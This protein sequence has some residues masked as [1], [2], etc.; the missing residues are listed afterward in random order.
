MNLSENAQDEID[1]LRAE[2]ERH[3]ELYY[4]RAEPEISDIDFDQLLERLK[5]IET[6]HP[7]LITPDSPT[8]RVGGKADSLRPFTHTVPLMSL[9]NSYDLNE[10]KAFTERCEKLAEGRTL[11]YVAELKIDGLSVSL[12]YDNGILMTGATRG[13]GQTG[14][15]VTQNVKTI[16]TIPLRLRKDAPER[17]EVRG[18]VFLSRSQFARINSELEMQGEKTF[19]N[20]RNCASGTLRMLDS[21]VVASRRLDMFPYDAYTGNQKMFATHWENFEWCERNGFN[22]NPNRRLCRDFEELAAFVA[23]IEAKRDSFDYEIDGVVV[24]VNSTA[25]QDEFGTT[26]KAPRWAIAYKYPARQATTRLLGIVIQVG[27]TGALT[28]VAHLE[29]TLLAGTTVSRASLHNEDE[30]K[31]LDL[32]IGDYVT[33]EKSGEIIPQVLS[34]VVSKRN[35]TETEFEFPRECP[36]CGFEAVRPEGEA[37][38]RCSNSDC[39]AKIKARILY[40]AARKAMDIEGLGEVLVE[41]LVDNGMIRDVAGLYSL[42]LDQVIGLERMAEKSGSNLIDEIEA[43]KGRGLQRLLFGIDIRHVGERTA[44]ILAGHFRS[45]DR[46]AAASVDELKAIFEIGQT[47]AESVHDWFRDMANIDLVE[48]LKAAG[49]KTE[50]DAASVEMLDER[51]IGKTFV[52]TGKLENYTRDEAAKF[53]EDRGG[54]VSSSVS[55]KTDYVVAGTDAGSKL[56]KAESLGVAML[57]EE[58]FREMIR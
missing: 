12:H 34:A 49:V 52:L 15:E 36:V 53:I 25:L 47:V 57:D 50:T 10:L 40:F 27:R 13:D 23:D 4:Q 11:E 35:G 14:D 18:E 44:K 30:I 29:P 33:I 58:Q 31:R 1:H 37:V 46:I 16:R 26:T 24:K 6:E 48:R 38:R 39:P 55:K 32:R 51:F 7:D 17:A 20:P 5:A 28:P 56:I 2:I 3:N 45:I 22:V 9:D 21:A 43:S 19:A 42:T 8:Q 54:R 41:T